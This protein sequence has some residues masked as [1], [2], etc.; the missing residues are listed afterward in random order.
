L[1]A[2]PERHANIA[3]VFAAPPPR[4]APQ[5]LAAAG[6]GREYARHDLDGGGLARVVRPN[7]ADRLA[8]ADGERHAAER[9][10]LAIAPPRHALQRAPQPRPALRHAIA[11]D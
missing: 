9:V 2:L 5:N 8:R 1:S 4:D 11:L 10:G 6:V 7:A 3:D